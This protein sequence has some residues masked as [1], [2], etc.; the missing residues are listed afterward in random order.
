MMQKFDVGASLAGRY[1]I[2]PAGVYAEHV[3]FFDDDIILLENLIKVGVADELAVSAEARKQVRHD[4]TPL[5]ASLS[6]LLDSKIKRA[7]SFWV[8]RAAA[9][10]PAA[11]A[12]VVH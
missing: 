7:W 4:A 5:D 6:H 10:D 12:I 3:A 11:I 2:R 9:V 8:V 1:R